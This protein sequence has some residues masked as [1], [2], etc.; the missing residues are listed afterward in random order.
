MSTIP[1]I[2]VQQLCFRLD[3]GEVLFSDL[4]FSITPGLTGL[5]GRNGSGKTVLA[6]LLVGELVSESGSIITNSRIEYFQQTD[7]DKQYYNNS[8]AVF[9]GINQK[10]QALS[11]IEQGICDQA[12]F[13]LVEEHWNLK[14]DIVSQL[15]HL[16]LPTDFNT[17]C[18]RLSGGELTI[19]KLWKLFNSDAD[20]LIL[21]EPSNHLD[22]RAKNW[23]KE[24][25]LSFK[26]SILL[27]SHDRKLLRQMNSILELNSLG[28]TLY[29]GNYD[30]YCVTKK[31][32]IN[33][34]ERNL[35]NEKSALLKIKT[36]HQNNQ[37]KAEKRQ[38]QG[39][40]VR[41]SGSQ[42][43]V[44]LNNARDRAEK[45]ASSRTI[46]RDNQL[47]VT[48]NKIHQ[49]YKQREQLK[50]QMFHFDQPIEKNHQQLQVQQLKLPYGTRQSISFSIS[51][52][53]KIQLTGNNGCGKST[54][55]RILLDPCK[56]IAGSI[57]HNSPLFY[58]DQH[59]AL[60]KPGCSLLEIL[61][62]YCP[63]IAESELRTLL[64]GIGFKRE[65]VTRKVQ[66]LSGGEKM[67][68]CI[69]IISH[70]SPVPILLLDEPDNHL[71]LESKLILARALNSYQGSFI[72]ISHDEDFIG[73]INLDDKIRLVEEA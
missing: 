19:L 69:L 58:L 39:N 20:L 25:I 65:S 56:A 50:T 22:V 32:K 8:I 53:Q 34:I 4:N 61:S 41:K 60:L 28:V 18:G 21:D 3:S 10:L 48:E 9:I 52:N 30:A 43:K 31:N 66:H 64:A 54:L 14:Q 26:G 68:L 57:H 29:G 45:S 59:F 17:L 24:K 16:N 33:A 55:M 46:Q 5:V 7:A 49:L 63:S 36:Q 12:D 38:S 37:E 15:K 35:S 44:M 72:L 13:D 1:L 23:L 42:A 51:G 62:L 40:R 73:E 11:R 47:S 6:S 71:D 70:Q 67:K 2:N 27:I